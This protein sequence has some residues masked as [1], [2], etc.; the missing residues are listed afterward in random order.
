M[1]AELGFNAYVLVG[2]VLNYLVNGVCVDSEAEFNAPAT[3]ITS[4]YSKIEP[5]TPR[6]I[7]PAM[8]GLAPEEKSL[9]DRCCRYCLRTMG[10][11]ETAT[12]LG[13]PCDAAE[14]VL[15]QLALEP[16]ANA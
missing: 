9:L 13:L 4:L 15:A 14:D 8:A 2:N 16:T 3:A 1:N 6:D 5:L 11:G 12:L 7:L 10:E